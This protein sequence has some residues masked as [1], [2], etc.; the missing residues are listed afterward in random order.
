MNEVVTIR[1][2]NLTIAPLFQSS[3]SEHPT[4]IYKMTVKWG[5]FP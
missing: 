3:V 2:A 5:D 4:N 1:P